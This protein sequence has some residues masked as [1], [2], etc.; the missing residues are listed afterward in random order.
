VTHVPL[1]VLN[2]IAL[3]FWLDRIRDTGLLVMFF[4]TVPFAL[5]IGLIPYFLFVVLPLRLQ[6]EAMKENEWHGLLVPAVISL[7]VGGFLLYRGDSAQ[8]SLIGQVGFAAQSSFIPCLLV[9][10]GRRVARLQVSTFN[11]P[12]EP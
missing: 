6:A 5:V 8:N 10:W 11:D 9:L 2:T 1:Y 12:R 4:I 7:A 3:M